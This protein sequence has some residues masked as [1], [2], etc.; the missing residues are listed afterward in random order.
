ME[1]KF[2][3]LNPAINDLDGQLVK[4]SIDLHH[5]YNGIILDAALMLFSF[6]FVSYSNCDGHIATSGHS[7]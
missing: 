5:Y 6:Y 3:C 4:S 1:S 2:P 7:P